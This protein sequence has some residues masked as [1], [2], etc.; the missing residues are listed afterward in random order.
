M[1]R[2]TGFVPRDDRERE[3]EPAGWG[4][5]DLP[6]DD[7]WEL[8]AGELVRHPDP[9]ALHEEVCSR[10]SACVAGHL[11]RTLGGRLFTAPTPWRLG[12][13]DVVRPDLGVLFEAAAARPGR[14]GILGP[15]TVVFEVLD[16]ATREHDL[17]RKRRLYERAGV[18]EYWIADPLWRRRW[19]WVL[20][21]GRYR[22]CPGRSPH[23]PGLSLPRDEIFPPGG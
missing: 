14:R 23:L 15:P 5:A 13:E 12:A 11:A 9:G 16:P 17:E 19:G 7:R 20:A 6:A 8:I 1:G 21:A 18:L 4:G 2:G 3:R 10:L 22:L